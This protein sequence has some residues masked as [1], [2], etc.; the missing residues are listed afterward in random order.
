M[1]PWGK[2][3]RGTSWARMGE[4]TR[5]ES[6]VDDDSRRTARA[7]TTRRDPRADP[8]DDDAPAPRVDVVNI[9]RPDGLASAANS[10]R[11]DLARLSQ[12]AAVVE[13]TLED[14]RRQQ[15]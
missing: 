4:K 10:L 13:R 1:L 11:R 7:E 9:D 3:F 8:D 12:Q 15:S 6:T 5:T 14:Q 2:S